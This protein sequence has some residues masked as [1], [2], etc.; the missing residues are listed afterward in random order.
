VP[1]TGMSVKYEGTGITRFTGTGA[2]GQINFT[3]GK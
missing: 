1:E 2:Y 3:P